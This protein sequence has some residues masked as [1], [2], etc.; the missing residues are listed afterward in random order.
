M[1]VSL[2]EPSGR[3]IQPTAKAQLLLESAVRIER[4]LEETKQRILEIRG[5]RPQGV[6]IAAIPAIAAALLPR[7]IVEFRK[8]YPDVPQI[9][10]RLVPV[11]RSYSDT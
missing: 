4:E 5:G 6:R 11:R 2:F 9:P 10:R 8:V 1:M 7:A 3:N